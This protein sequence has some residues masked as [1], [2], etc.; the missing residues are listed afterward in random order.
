[1]TRQSYSFKDK[2]YWGLKKSPKFCILESKLPYDIFQ[3]YFIASSV[4]WL[5]KGISNALEETFKG[6]KRN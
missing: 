4:D 2:Y 5:Q 1:M 3:S 6:H